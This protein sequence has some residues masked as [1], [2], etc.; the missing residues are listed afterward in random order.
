MAQGIADTSNGGLI[1]ALATKTLDRVAVLAELRSRGFYAEC[2]TLTADERTEF[3]A[4]IH[5]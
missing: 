5:N 3:D 1:A 2:V 4:D